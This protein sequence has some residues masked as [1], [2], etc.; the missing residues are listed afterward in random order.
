MYSINGIGT[1][2]YGKKD[3]N[4]VDQSYIATK[5][6]TFLLLPI[7]PLGSYRVI[8]ES[9]KDTGNIL[10]LGYRVNYKMIKAKWCWSQIFMTYFAT[11]GLFIGGIILLIYLDL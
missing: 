8:R 1:K 5:W 11:W 2:L 9:I 4:H 7:I 3:F 6:F 10:I